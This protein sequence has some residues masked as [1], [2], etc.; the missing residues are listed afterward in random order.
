[1]GRE[2]FRINAEKEIGKTEVL[3]EG[4][5]SELEKLRSQF[6]EVDSSDVYPS[7]EGQFQSTVYFYR[8]DEGFRSKLFQFCKENLPEPHK[9]GQTARMN[10]F[11]WGVIAVAGILI[12]YFLFNLVWYLQSIYFAAKGVGQ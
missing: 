12:A 10:F 3:Y 4:N 9:Q 11:K 6:R 1:M 2:P 5:E 8:A 7:F